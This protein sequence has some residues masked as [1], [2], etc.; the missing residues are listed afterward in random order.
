MRHESFSVRNVRT[1]LGLLTGLFL[2]IQSDGSRHIVQN[3]EA[4]AEVVPVNSVDTAPGTLD[5]EFTPSFWKASSVS[6]T[7]LQ[8]DGKLL[9]AGSFIRVN[10]VLRDVMGSHD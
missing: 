7:A 5:N 9:I 10:G 3:R 8:P 2:L 6:E 4:N 1:N